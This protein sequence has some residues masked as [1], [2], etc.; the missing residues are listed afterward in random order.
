MRQ[1]EKRKLGASSEPHPG[2]QESEFPAYA[3]SKLSPEELKR[4]YARQVGEQKAV[5]SRP[6]PRDGSLRII[7]T[8][9]SFKK[10]GYAMLE[11][12]SQKMQSQQILYTHTQGGERGGVR[13]KWEQENG[14]FRFDSAELK[15][16]CSQPMVSG[17]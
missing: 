8:G 5:V 16:L 10:P 6:K 11:Q 12:L 13:Y 4:L 14:I 9:H 3:A 2:W 15:L 1:P 17:T 7:G